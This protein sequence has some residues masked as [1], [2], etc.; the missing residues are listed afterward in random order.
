MGTLQPASKHQLEDEGYTTDSTK[1][2]RIEGEE[3]IDGDE[4]PVWLD[5]SARASRSTQRVDRNGEDAPLSQRARDKQPRKGSNDSTTLSD[6]DMIVD[7][8]ESS[9]YSPSTARGKKRERVDSGSMFGGEGALEAETTREKK[10]RN[11]R[12]SDVNSSSSRG[13]KRD[14]DVQDEIEEEA[15]ETSPQVIRKKRGK[16]TQREPESKADSSMESVLEKGPRREI[17]EEWESNGVEY[18]IGPNGQ[19]L[20]KTLKRTPQKCP[21]VSSLDDYRS[22]LTLLVAAGGLDTS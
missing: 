17:G 7:Y 2:T 21:M 22:V 20:R 3:L 10:R 8:Q 14:R 13:K 19:R 16:R 15:D 4:D 9:S 12:R 5:V 6:D 18:K 11:K 1:K